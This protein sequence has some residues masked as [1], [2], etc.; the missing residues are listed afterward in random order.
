MIKITKDEQPLT[1]DLVG[2]AA[3]NM[4]D[5]ANAAGVVFVSGVVEALGGDYDAWQ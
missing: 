2:F 3:F 1:D 4:G 5:K